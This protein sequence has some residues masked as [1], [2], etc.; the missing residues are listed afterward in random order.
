MNQRDTLRFIS[1]LEKRDKKLFGAKS[2]L[3]NVTLVDL[4]NEFVTQRCEYEKL[5]NLVQAE[6]KRVKP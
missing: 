6:A 4:M 1:R 5:I 2:K 3:L